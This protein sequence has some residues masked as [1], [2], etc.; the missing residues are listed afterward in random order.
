MSELSADAHPISFLLV[1]LNQNAHL[2]ESLP[3]SNGGI[4]SCAVCDAPVH[5]RITRN[6]C[7]NTG[8]ARLVPNLASMWKKSLIEFSMVSY[9]S[10]IT[11]YPSTSHDLL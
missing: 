5:A 9:D 4:Y 3:H 8:V 2:H 7:E 11:R 1:V 10:N 6:P